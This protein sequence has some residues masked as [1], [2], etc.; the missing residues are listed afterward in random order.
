MP[1][2]PFTLKRLFATA[3]SRCGKFAFGELPVL[4]QRCE[5]GRFGL[6]RTERIEQ[7]PLRTRS[8]ER[9]R[10][11]LTVNVHQLIAQF[12][13]QCHRSGLTVDQRA[14][15]AVGF[16]DAPEKQLARVACEIAPGKPGIEAF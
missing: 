7:R 1:G 11:M 4:E 16:D 13:Q 8:Q 5:R 14:R 12:A 6:E 2:E 10:R 15:P 3:G 9:L